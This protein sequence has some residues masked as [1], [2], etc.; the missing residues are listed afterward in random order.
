MTVISRL[1]KA[2]VEVHTRSEWG[3][4]QQKA[5]AYR[6]R[7]RTHLMAE[8]TAKYHFLHITVTSDTDTVQQGA[9]GARQIEHYGYSSPPMVSYQDLIT[10]EGRYF[11]GQN[12]RV[13][14]THTI[15]DKNVPGF[16]HD[17]NA[18]GYALALMQNVGDAVTD[19]QVDVA[20]KV[21]AAR[22]LEGLVVR[23]APVYPHRK[24]AYKSCPGDKAMERL[25]EIVAL[26]NKYVREGMKT[27]RKTKLRKTPDS[28]VRVVEVNCDSAT[29]GED[30]QHVK[31]VLREASTHA[32]VL[33]ACECFDIDAA[34]VLPTFHVAQ[35]GKRG[36]AEAGSIVA[37]RKSRGF[38]KSE[39]LR[40]GAPAWL[41][42][43]VR[44]RYWVITKLRIDQMKARKFSAGHAHPKR[45][46]ARWAAYMAK[47]PGGVLG[48]DGNKA[49]KAIRAR[50]P[51]KKIRQV[52]L[53]A[54]VIPRHIPASPVR[55][56]DV[57]GDHKA[58][59]TT[60]WPNA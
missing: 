18:H 40:R 1:R 7:R 8:V 56:I 28:P 41:A 53:L 15:N 58:A 49:R 50:F 9:A 2:G 26:K 57:D 19:I 29:P 11:E 25:D 46:W 5:G 38:I 43:N 22:E 6:K 23:G 27:V 54:I 3:S 44:A 35:F 30:A 51:S 42:R 20:A 34:S 48:F 45:A 14:G 32:D 36:S 12:Y 55:A 59:A 33:L 39:S 16:P 17:L 47:A 21:F 13:K 37:I 10:N 24:F 4:P 52:G 60:L 31:S